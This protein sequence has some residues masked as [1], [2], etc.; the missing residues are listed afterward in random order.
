LLGRTNFKEDELRDYF[1][2]AVGDDVLCLSKKQNFIVWNQ[3]QWV[4]DSGC[5]LGHELM[6]L[7]HS[8]FQRNKSVWDAKLSELVRAGRGDSDEA[9]KLRGE[10]IAIG[11]T[12]NSYGNQTNQNVLALIKNALRARTR[13]ATTRSI[14]SPMSLRSATVR[15]RPHASARRRWLV[16]TRQVRLSA[17]VVPEAVARAHRRGD[18]QGGLV[19]REHL[20]GP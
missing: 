9:E 16:H 15:I 10:I 3:E 11:K 12:A 13:G 19:V 8:L 17:H 20:S 6:T 4:E 1:L 18:G 14:S 2:K 5:I 7:V